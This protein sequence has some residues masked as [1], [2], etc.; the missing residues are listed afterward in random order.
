MAVDDIYTKVLLHFDGTEGST[1]IIDESGKEWG[2][3]NQAQ[4]DTTVKKFGTASLI[5]DGVND[6]V[7]TEERE[8]FDLNSSDGAVDFW[9]YPTSLASV[10]VTN[11]I[12]GSSNNT[13]ETGMNIHD[14]GTLAIGVIGTNEETTEAGEIEINNWYHI[15]VQRTDSGGHTRV[16]INGVNKIDTT[17]D[18][19]VTPG[20]IM[21]IGA[22]YRGSAWCSFTGNIEEFRWSKGV[23]RYPGTAS[24]T[25]PTT[26]YGGS[27]ATSYR[28]QMNSNTNFW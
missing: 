10:G 13:N 25:P 4:L 23:I 14:D 6:Y 26:P 22:Y 16:F 21:K 9:I 27:S 7:Y 15:A 1:E 2:E 20:E 5:C 12:W 3:V 17:T 19:W 24:F 8:D 18:V 28:T 11:G